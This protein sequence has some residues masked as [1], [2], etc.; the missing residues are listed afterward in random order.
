MIRIGIIGCGFMGG[1]HAA[2][3]R[4]LESLGVAV[5]AVADGRAEFGQKLAAECGAAWFDDG[6]KLIESD[7][8]DAVDICLPTYLHTS[9]AA[10][11]M[12][13]GKAVFVEKPVCI[14]ETD[15]ALLQQIRQE[16]GAALQ[17]GHVVRFWPEYQWL[18]ETKD[19]GTY[20]AFLCGSF[21]R[22]SPTPL[23]AS[24]G[25]LHKPEYSG[26]LAIDMH[27]HDV[28]FVRYLLGEPDHV[29]VSAYRDIN[30]LIQEIYATYGY[31]D[32][33]A[34][35]LSAGWDYPNTFPFDASFRVKFERAVVT[36]EK[37]RLTVYPSDG[38]P[39]CPDVE[40]FDGDCQQGGNVSSLGGYYNEL[41]YF[42]E[43]LLGVHPLELATLDD[44]IASVRL[45]KREVELVGGFVKTKEGA[46]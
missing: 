37:D 2:C 10:A 24:N 4:A 23:W 11:A 26:G 15:M 34:V 41:K 40:T 30:G 18:K 28:D 7:L 19:A 20:G 36:L 17:V 1:M 45:A 8:V 39:F 13:A 21:R 22:L 14:T 29:A 5:T 35:T 44:A 38:E 3:Y 12:K 43:G 25:W 9:H 27:I 6:M 42:A 16:T 46:D 31:G 32:D 33:V